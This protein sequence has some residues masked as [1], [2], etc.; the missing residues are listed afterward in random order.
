MSLTSLYVKHSILGVNRYDSE[1][2]YRLRM[3]ISAVVPGHL[4]GTR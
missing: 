2:A 4:L 1:L 3:A